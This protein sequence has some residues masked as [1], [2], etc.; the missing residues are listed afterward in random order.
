VLILTGYLLEQ[1]AQTTPLALSA[2][3][4]FEQTYGEVD[5]DSAS[6]AELYALLSGLAGAPIHQGIAVT[7]SVNQRGEIQAVGGVTTKI[8]GFYAVCKAQGLDGHQGV[9]IPA[10]NVRQLMLRP[11]V[12][13]AVAAGRF[14]IW[15]IRHVD[16]GLQLLTGL[17]AGTVR[18]NGTFPSGSLHARVQK[19]LTK[20]T[21]RL[22]AFRRSGRTAARNGQAEPTFRP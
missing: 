9:I 4:T 10:T 5:G 15:A 7:G 22:A 1:Y 19:R 2:R 17:Q 11:E 8:E 20:L 3:L 16:E 6:S 13:E 14:H 12:V 18:A 21:T